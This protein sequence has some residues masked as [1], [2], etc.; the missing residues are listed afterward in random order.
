MLYTEQDNTAQGNTEK[1]SASK[2]AVALKKWQA[3]PCL[4]PLS[5]LTFLKEIPGHGSLSGGRRLQ[6]S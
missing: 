5:L 3:S 6:P 2:S 4:A 1:H